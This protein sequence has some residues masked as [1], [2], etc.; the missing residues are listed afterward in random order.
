MAVLKSGYTKINRKIAMLPETNIKQN[1]AKV[2]TICIIYE[3]VCVCV[4]NGKCG[5]NRVLITRIHTLIGCQNIDIGD[6]ALRSTVQ[7]F[8]LAS[9]FDGFSR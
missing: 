8:A 6:L 1:K 9:G 4:W 7:W 5:T 2:Y 3:C